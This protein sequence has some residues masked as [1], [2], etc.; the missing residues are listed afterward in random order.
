MTSRYHD[1]TERFPALGLIGNTPL[2]RIDAFDDEIPRKVQIHAKAEFVN[3]GGSIKD[4]PVLRMLTEAVSSGE[5]T[6]ERTILDSSSGN[7]GIAYAMIGA[8]RGFRVRLCV[9]GNVT[10]ER[11]KVLR[12]FGADVVFTSPMEGSDG[13]ILKARELQAAHPDLYFYPDQYNNDSNW[14]A[15][16][17]TTGPEILEQT[18]GRVT[19]FVAGLGTSGTFVGVGRRLRAFKSSISKSVLTRSAPS[20]DRARGRS[21]SRGSRP[22]CPPRSCGRR[23][24]SSRTPRR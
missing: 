18:G 14:K 12:A 15:H 2:V 24:S 11:K 7:A 23:A 8:A 21:R 22:A 5:L 9:P 6:Q 17:D 4:R 10:P 19:H 16:Y 13:A 3:P 20:R 1:W